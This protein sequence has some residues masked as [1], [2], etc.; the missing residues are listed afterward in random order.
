MSNQRN[1]LRRPQRTESQYIT[2]QTNVARYIELGSA[3]QARGSFGPPMSGPLAA[4]LML[5]ASLISRQSF[6]VSA[7]L[8]T[9]STYLL[10]GDRR[11]DVNS[12]CMARERSSTAATGG[13]FSPV[14]AARRRDSDPASGASIVSPPSARMGSRR[15]G[16]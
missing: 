9:S 4:A 5:S 3:A 10:T 12:H 14:E 11:N 16:R 15:R 8:A 13:L 6:G 7:P 2:V 1:A